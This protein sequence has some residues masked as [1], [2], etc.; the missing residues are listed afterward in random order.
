MYQVITEE[1]FP[2]IKKLNGDGT[3]FA[4]HMKDARFTLPPE[5]AGLLAKVVD[6]L[7]GIPMEDRTMAKPFKWTYQ[8]KPL[9]A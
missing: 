4:V 6:I 3:A 1:V 9:T 8:G 7:D 2:F 5:K